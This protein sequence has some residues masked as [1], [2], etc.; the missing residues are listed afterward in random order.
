MPLC[1]EL[2]AAGE[3]KVPNEERGKV[4]AEGVAPPVPPDAATA[5]GTAGADEPG[6]SVLLLV[7]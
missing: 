5:A 6:V 2:D 1:Q 3:E 7:E 4:G